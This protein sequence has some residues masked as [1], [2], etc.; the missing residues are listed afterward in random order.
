[1]PNAPILLENLHAI[2]TAIDGELPRFWRMNR[3]EAYYWG[4]QY[5]D[6]EYE[7]NDY[8]VFDS[9]GKKKVVKLAERK[10][11]IIVDIPKAMVNTVVSFLFSRGRFP[12]LSGVGEVAQQTLDVIKRQTRLVSVA[13]QVAALGNIVGSVFWVFHVFNGRFTLKGYNGKV[14]YPVFDDA[15]P[16][17][18][19]EVRIVY[20]YKDSNGDWRWFRKDYTREAVIL[21]DNPL[22]QSGEVPTFAEVEA[23][24]HDLGFV[25]GVWVRNLNA[26]LPFPGSEMDGASLY[27]GQ[28]T[29]S[30]F[31]SVNYMTSLMDRSLM[32][33][34]D[35]QVILKGLTQTD[36]DRA[37][38]RSS[39]TPW[40]LGKDG[41]ASLLEAE[42]TT[43]DKAEAF[44]KAR[45]AAVL[46]NCRVIL[47]DPSELDIKADSSRAL[48]RLFSP[49]L[50]L[51]DEERVNYGE[52]GMALLLQKMLRAVD[53]FK[54]RGLG[55][56]GIPNGI[57]E[58]DEVN[59]SW[60]NFF[61]PSDA[62]LK[63][64]LERV[65]AAVGADLLSQET[66]VSYIKSDFA[67]EDAAA[68]L[69]LIKK[70]KAERVQSF[71]Q[72]T[73]DE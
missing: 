57:L 35:P 20:K 43:Y 38:L 10:P 13:K 1:M 22:A 67:V 69:D 19:V 73:L 18:P 59:L 33:N 4:W 49:M 61:E 50:G 29:L 34:L 24:V 41:E 56:Q 9:E 44:I 63:D 62:E 64:N 2:R 72:P 68:E 31:D 40:V 46:K 23:S 27:E 70:E 48:E 3:L 45:V 14:C 55:I 15:D 42:G 53:I 36:Y 7:W 28:G 52:D 37:A 39:R 32:S 71:S 30:H 47:M 54:S 11:K 5:A 21:Y 26:E 51:I 60:G 16:F 6:L 25:P 58:G 65:V 8:D 66:A 17:E 12:D